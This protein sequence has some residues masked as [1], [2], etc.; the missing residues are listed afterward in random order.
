LKITLDNKDGGRGGGEF[1]FVAKRK[2]GREEVV[3]GV[4][5]WSQIINIGFVGKLLIAT[6]SNVEFR[7]MGRMDSLLG[8]ETRLDAVI[9]AW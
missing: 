4:V 9:I 1:G 6:V 7:G 3:L 2:M 8:V 5:E